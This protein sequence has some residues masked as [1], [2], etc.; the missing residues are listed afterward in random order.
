M[1]PEE[2]PTGTGAPISDCD[3]KK[4]TMPCNVYDV[5]LPSTKINQIGFWKIR[6]FHSQVTKIVSI[7]VT[8]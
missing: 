6:M 3:L 2:G 8:A 5:F 7:S 4:F 1:I